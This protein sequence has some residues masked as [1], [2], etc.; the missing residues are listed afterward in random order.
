MAFAIEEQTSEWI[1]AAP[2]RVEIAFDVQAPPESVFSVLSDDV[3]WP[4]WYAGVRS[5][6]LTNGAVGEGATRSVWFRAARVDERV[7]LYEEPCRIVY[8]GVSSNVPG[9]KSVVTD[10][11]IVPLGA[12]CSRLTVAVGLECSG[13]L[14]LVPWLV[15]LALGRATRGAR[16]IARIVG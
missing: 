12:G 11:R 15:R 5:V 3:S 16:G 8:A 10:W 4:V 14:R 1:A 9:L 7:L 6:R 2:T 13:P